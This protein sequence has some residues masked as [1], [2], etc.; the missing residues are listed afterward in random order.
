M[1]LYIEQ[2]RMAARQP[3]AVPRPY[4]IR[5]KIARRAI[6]HHSG[7]I[8]YDRKRCFDADSTYHRHRRCHSATHYPLSCVHL[9]SN[10]CN[11]KCKVMQ[12]PRHFIP[13]TAKSPPNAAFRQLSSTLGWGGLGLQLRLLISGGNGYPTLLHRLLCAIG[14]QF[15]CVAL[16]ADLRQPVVY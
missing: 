3:P 14:Y 4:H 11:Y 8:F 15:A 9:H 6:P 7:A 2:R 5:R 10:K 1:R 13:L 12:N 16:L